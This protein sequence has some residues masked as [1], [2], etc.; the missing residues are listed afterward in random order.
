MKPAWLSNFHDKHCPG[1]LKCPF[2]SIA[3]REI[4]QKRQRMVLS[5]LP[6]GIQP[7][8]FNTLL[9]MNYSL[10]PRCIL[11]DA[12][13]L[14]CS[15]ADLTRA[16]IRTIALTGAA[17]KRMSLYFSQKEVV[18]RCPVGF[19]KQTHVADTT[20]LRSN[21]H[22][23]ISYIR[24]YTLNPVL[25]TS[26]RAVLFLL[27]VVAALQPLVSHWIKTSTGLCIDTQTKGA[28]K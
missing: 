14:Y 27:F 8:G 19:S 15:T 20:L 17:T 26:M 2:G 25:F 3:T 7:E 21:K 4:E 9:D 23:F 18:L 11:P 1:P 6:V 13:C 16:G 22:V 24:I 28:R 10:S 5:Q 12:V